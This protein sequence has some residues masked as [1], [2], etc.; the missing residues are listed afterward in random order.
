MNIAICDDD[1]QDLNILSS[2]VKQYSQ[3]HLFEIHCF[4][5]AES[6]Y[7]NS[8][9]THFDIIILDIEMP[10]PNGY[11]IAKRLIKDEPKPLIIFVTNSMEYT[12]IGYGIAF[13]Y[14]P[15]PLSYEKLSDALNIAIN[16]VHSNRFVFYLE[17]ISHVLRIEDIYYFEVFEHNIH[18]H[19]LNTEYAFRDTLKNILSKLPPGYFG[20][21]HQS[22]VVNF[23][24]I[25]HAGSTEIQL[26]NGTHIPISRRKATQ[27]QNAFHKYLGR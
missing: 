18:I 5:S 16:E 19:T 7:N 25:Q 24:H 9:L 10:G 21:P 8:K 12:I 4:T 11:E 22:Y 26:T 15:K 13:R 23:H 14:I 2:L 6:L 27:F 20:I 17:G 3:L 1:I